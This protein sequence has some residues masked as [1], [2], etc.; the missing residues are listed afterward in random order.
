MITQIINAVSEIWDN[1][2]KPEH[3]KR[4]IKEY[5][6]Q[7]YQYNNSDESIPQQTHTHKNTTHPT[8]NRKFHTKNTPEGIWNRRGWVPVWTGGKT[9]QLQKITHADFGLNT[10]AALPSHFSSHSAFPNHRQ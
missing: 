4:V 6:E 1:D 5:Y 3:I 8:A 9:V 10:L 7:L 2:I